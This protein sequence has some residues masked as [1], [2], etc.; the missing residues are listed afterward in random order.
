MKLKRMIGRGESEALEFK[1][2]ATTIA[3]D[4]NAPSLNVTCFSIADDS[5]VSMAG[6]SKKKIKRAINTAAEHPYYVKSDTLPNNMPN[7][8]EGVRTLSGNAFFNPLSP[9][10]IL[11]FNLNDKAAYGTSF[12]CEHNFLHSS[13]LS[14]NLLI[15]INSIWSLTKENTLINSSLEK[16]E[17]L[18]ILSTLLPISKNKNS[19]DTTSNLLITLFNSKINSGLPRINN[20]ENTVL[21]STTSSI[22]NHSLRSLLAIDKLT[23]SANSLTCSSVAFDLDTIDSISF[24]LS[25]SLFKNLENINCQSISEILLNSLLISSGTSTFNSAI[26]TSPKDNNE[27]GYLKVSNDIRIGEWVELRNKTFYIEAKL[28]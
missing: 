24:I 9:E 19:G 4:V 6:G 5:L 20:A 3:R 7:A 13:V 8:S 12:S 15:G 21:A 10:R 28:K 25:N 2:G 14:E 23:S 18:S 27:N 17:N 1:E 22:P 26:A 16:C 11:Q